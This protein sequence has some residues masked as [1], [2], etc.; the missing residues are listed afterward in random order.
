MR[1]E[2]DIKLGFKDVMIRPKRSTL[3]S[4]S[5]VSLLRK[6]PCLH[7]PG[8]WEGIPILAAN[9]DTTGTFDIARTLGE[10]KLFT[11]IH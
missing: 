2:N 3:K 9:I 1:I 7:A 5:E 6:F 10:A 8:E 11:V 4:R